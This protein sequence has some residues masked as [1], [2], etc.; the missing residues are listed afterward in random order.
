MTVELQRELD[1]QMAQYGISAYDPITM[2]IID[3]TTIRRTEYGGIVN[4]QGERIDCIY[5]IYS[6]KDCYPIIEL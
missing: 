3:V 6:C 4:I 5:S 1:L 2:E